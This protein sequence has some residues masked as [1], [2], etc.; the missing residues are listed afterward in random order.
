MQ[1]AVSNQT[2]TKTFRYGPAIDVWVRN[3]MLVALAV[4][5]DETPVAEG[6]LQDQLAR[7]EAENPAT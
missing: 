4:F 1:I 3:R 5:R 2:T 6:Q 7:L